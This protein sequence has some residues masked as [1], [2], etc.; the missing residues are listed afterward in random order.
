MLMVNMTNTPEIAPSSESVPSRRGVTVTLWIA[1]WLLGV[2]LVGAGIFKLSLGAEQAVELFPWSADVPAL[3][4]VTSVLDVLGGLGVVLPAITRILPRLTSLAAL[5][6]LA[7]ML[8]AV[9]FS[10][11]RGEASEIAPNL[12][13]AGVAAFIA[14][15]RWRAA[16]ITAQLPEPPRF[17]GAMPL[18]DAPAGMAIFQLPT[19]TYETRGAFAV[20]GGAFGDI[21]Q[22][23]ATSVLVRHPAGDL[24]IDAGFGAHAAEHIEML[25]SFRRS[26]HTVG[27]TVSEQL[28][29]AGYDRARLRGVLL[30]HSHW[31]HVSGLDSLAV[32]IWMTA[33]ERGYAS[34]SKD[35]AV[36]TSVARNHGIREYGFDG[37]AYLGFDASHDAY[38]DGSVVIVPAAGHTTGSVIVFVTLPSG[39]RFAFIGDLTWQRDG[40][41]RRVERPLLLSMLADSD[42]KQVRRDLLRMIALEGRMQI[43]PAHDVASYDGIPLLTSDAAVTR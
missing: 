41:T 42:A 24:L 31:D 4:T 2:S 21:R 40:I 29:A 17:T 35:D 19:G 28:D 9:A 15:G 43:V 30:T 8:S 20:R 32:P 23:A 13:L 27:A 33:D 37:P 36:F 18:A 16:P 10:L 25:P 22:F 14:W 5:G 1:Q 34:A 38:G 7:L 11:S 39:E 3:F 12:V 26:P 6:V